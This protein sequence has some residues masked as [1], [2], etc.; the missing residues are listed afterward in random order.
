MFYSCDQVEKFFVQESTAIRLDDVMRIVDV[1]FPSAYRLPPSVPV[2]DEILN[3]LGIPEILKVI[4][5]G[6]ASDLVDVL[7]WFRAQ[8][9]S[10]R[11]L[12]SLFLRDKDNSFSPFDSFDVIARFLL[13]AK[14]Q[15]LL[16][17][18][19][20]ALERHEQTLFA[21]LKKLE[22]SVRYSK[23]RAFSQAMSELPLS[24]TVSRL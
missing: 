15:F 23:Q 5:S 7:Y 9:I 18:R 2:L 13:H 16:P 12:S 1:K 22:R 6:S 17:N 20:A 10:E 14:R 4:D 3:F 21:S 24:S 19:T 11:S 8:K